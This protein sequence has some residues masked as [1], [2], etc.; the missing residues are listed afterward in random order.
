M[1]D[2][3]QNTAHLASLGG[4]EIPR[5]RFLA[6]LRVAVDQAP[7]HWRFDKSALLATLA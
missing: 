2:C 3:Q 4:A 1:I 5:N 6:E 7:V